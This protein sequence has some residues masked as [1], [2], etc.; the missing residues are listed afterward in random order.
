MDGST[1][2]KPRPLGAGDLRAAMRFLDWGHSELK[3]N[4]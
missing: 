3:G 4:S 2:K 1:S